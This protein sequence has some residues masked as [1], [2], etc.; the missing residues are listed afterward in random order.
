MLVVGPGVGALRRGLA[1]GVVAAV[2]RR[3]LGAEVHA[4]PLHAQPEVDEFEGWLGGLGGA[5]TRLDGAHDDAR[6]AGGCRGGHAGRRGATIEEKGHGL[7]GHVG[8]HVLRVGPDVALSAVGAVFRV[9]LVS[10]HGEEDGVA[11]GAFQLYALHAVHSGDGGG[12]LVEQLVG[13]V[14]GGH[15]PAVAPFRK[16]GVVCRARDV[17]AEV[18]GRRRRAVGVE[19]VAPRVGALRGC[20]APGVEV[21]VALG[22]GGSHVAGGP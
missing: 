18:P 12:A 13:L 20:L 9:I 14:E 16:G 6:A 5:R 21:A 17:R 15:R 10:R 19:V 11:V 3:V 8:G 22:R 1:P 7:V 2:A 4:A